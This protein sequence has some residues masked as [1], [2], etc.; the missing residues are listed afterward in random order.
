MYVHISEVS[1]LKLHCKPNGDRAYLANRPIWLLP[2][3]IQPWYYWVPRPKD[4]SWQRALL[5]RTSP[6]KFAYAIFVGIRYLKVWA[7]E[8]LRPRI[9]PWHT[10]Q[11]LRS[12]KLSTVELSLDGLHQSSHRRFIVWHISISTANIH[13][14]LYTYIN[15]SYIILYISGCVFKSKWSNWKCEFQC[16]HLWCT[17]SFDHN[18]QR[19]FFSPNCF[20]IPS[21]PIRFS[22]IRKKTH[23]LTVA[24]LVVVTLKKYAIWYMVHQQ[25][26]D[27]ITNQQTS[28]ILPQS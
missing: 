5:P 22:V 10:T 12:P 20:T 3:A 4:T 1:Q 7:F 16:H 11:I 18:V 9:G 15:I 28:N 19:C 13:T 8:K 25:D 6:A 24:V 2:L 23:H 27:N 17:Q 14:I 21:P 26:A